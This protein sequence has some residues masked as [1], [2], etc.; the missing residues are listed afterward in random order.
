MTTVTKSGDELARE[1]WGYISEIW[2]GHSGQTRF[3][4]ACAAIGASPPVLKALLSMDAS[5]PTTMGALAS[6]IGCDASWATSL[7]DD[8]ETLGYAERQVLAADRRVKTVVLTAAG[9][10]AKEAAIDHL[11]APPELLKRLT[12]SELR[13]LAALLRKA[14]GPA[15]EAPTSKAEA[16]R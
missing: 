13:E 12:T 8:L 11:H 3:H 2:F 10:K 1:A 4:T 14:F 16:T 9:V 15:A 5:A 6:H 7:V